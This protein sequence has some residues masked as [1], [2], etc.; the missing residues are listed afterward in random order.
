M[1]GKTV[2]FARGGLRLASATLDHALA[3]RR[4]AITAVHG[5]LTGDEVLVFAHYSPVG[6][7][8]PWEVR[9][10]AFAKRAGLCVCVVTNLDAGVKCP[11]PMWADCADVVI[12]RFNIGRDLA[13][14]RDAIRYLVD[15]DYRGPIVLANDSVIWREDAH[16]DLA[17]R[18]ARFGAQV[19]GAT[20]SLEPFPH[21]QTPWLWLSGSVSKAQ[22]IQLSGLW[23][24]VRTR[25][26]AISYGELPFTHAATE[27]GLSTRAIFPYETV[28]AELLREDD[29]GDDVSGDTKRRR[30]R[31]LGAV[32]RGIALNPTH[33]MWS[34]LL[35]LGYPGIKRDLVRTNPVAIEDYFRIRAVAAGFGFDPDDFP[36]APN[37]RSLLSH[38]QERLVL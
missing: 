23:R 37:R 7:P 18:A 6:H 38:I 26:A 19:V 15:A 35:T 13:A 9:A 33:F 4:S 21:L 11:L 3:N 32:S 17:S 24:N 31:V 30:R 27:L 2:K 10:L 14:F 34:E 28:L 16:A 29:E 20:S 8:L 5:S 36:V 1:I 12:Q 22:L 25:G